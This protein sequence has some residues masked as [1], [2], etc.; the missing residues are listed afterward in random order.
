MDLS[1]N[2]E[3]FKALSDPTRLRVMRLLVGNRMEFCVDALVQC[4]E[5]QAY[6]ASRQ[7]K[8]M[9]QA[10]LL[11][12]RKQG[13]HVYYSLG[14]QHAHVAELIFQLVVELPDS[15]GIFT[16]DQ[17]RFESRGRNNEMIQG[18]EPIEQEGLPSN[19]L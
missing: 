11:Q 14:G 19:L 13:R 9:E 1:K 7:L 17:Y 3:V 12:S 8:I 4:L 18:D 5:L 16:E 15:E 2:T 6:N 10:G